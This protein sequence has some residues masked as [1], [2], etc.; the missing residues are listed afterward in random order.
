MWV[1]GVTDRGYDP[2]MPP[3]DEV[4]P[5]LGLGNMV[6]R[7]ALGPIGDRPGAWSL[8]AVELSS[9]GGTF[10]VEPDL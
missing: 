10:V 3:D 5:Q 1:R 9:S 6:R 2:G 8:S 7:H 4:H